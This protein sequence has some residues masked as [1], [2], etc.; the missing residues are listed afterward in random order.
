M[1]VTTILNSAQ[2]MLTN[3][4]Q[5]GDY[6]VSKSKYRGI[7]PLDGIKAAVNNKATVHYT[8]G[9][10]PWSN[11]E[12]GF[13]DAIAAAQKSDVAIVVVGT[14]SRDQ[15]ELWAGLNATYVFIHPSIH[16]H[17]SPNP[18]PAITNNQQNRRTRRRKQSPPRRCTNLSYKSHNQH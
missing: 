16:Y 12:S 15:D 9:C 4:L 5:Y 6:V 17:I 1:S 13:P 10:K 14:W 18:N 11:D 3:S 2:T 7:T 8:E